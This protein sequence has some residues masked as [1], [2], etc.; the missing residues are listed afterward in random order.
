MSTYV[1]DDDAVRAMV[2]NQQCWHPAAYAQKVMS[3][4]RDQTPPALPT[5]LGAVVRTDRGTFIRADVDSLPWRE[6]DTDAAGNATDNHGNW[7]DAAGIGRVVEILSEG[8][9]A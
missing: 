7:H 6:I 5:G 9:T 8:W 3:A 1:L 2:A 4:L